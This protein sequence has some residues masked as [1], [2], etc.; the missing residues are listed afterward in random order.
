MWA[1]RLS[2][3]IPAIVVFGCDGEK[4]QIRAFG[5]ATLAVKIEDPTI[6][7]SSGLARSNAFPG[8]YY[9]HN[10]SGDSARFWKFDLNGK[11]EGPFT[12]PSANAIDW[13][14]MSSATVDGKHYLYFGDIGDNP[15]HRKSVQ[16]YRVEEPKGKPGAIAK[17]EKFELTYPDGPHNAEALLVDRTGRI[18]LV[19]KTGRKPAQIFVIDTPKVSVTNALHEVGSVSVGGSLEP[20]KLI[21]GGNISADGKFLVLRTYLAAYEFPLAK[22]PEWWKAAPKTIQT[23]NEAQGEAIA[24]SLDG[25]ELLTSSEYSPCLISR[26][27]IQL[28][29]SDKNP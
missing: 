18:T 8:W 7:E 20:T 15:L 14:D 3:L 27:R 13:E 2:L 4:D 5:A 23:A 12:I 17:C 28:G 21:T 16:V 29:T 1:R 22:S 24:Y 25:R 19:A 26:I 6:N 10:D 11:V 9:T